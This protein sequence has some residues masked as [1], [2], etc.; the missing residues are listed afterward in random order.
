MSIPPFPGIDGLHPLV[1]HFP[2]ALLFVAPVFVLIGL[3][4]KP[5]HR[6]PFLVSA[7]IL[8]IGGTISAFVAGS[9]GEAAARLVHRSAEVSAV[10]EHHEDLAETTRVIFA[11]LT[12]TFT[13][14]L[15]GP[16]LLKRPPGTA[17]ATLLPSIF[18]LL[19]G[20]GMVVLAG[21]AHSGGRLVHEFGIHAVMPVQAVRRALP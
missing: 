10:L 15:F 20:A 21:T 8:M 3:L 7:W 12:V 2:V 18:L 13:V 6:S 19:Y 14:L 16:R 9:S 1:V 11:A 17:V 4:R 5:V